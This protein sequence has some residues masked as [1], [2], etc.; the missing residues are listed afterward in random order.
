MPTMKLDAVSITS[1]N[2]TKSAE[3]YRL[4]GFRFPAFDADAK[5]LEPMAEPG[6][7]RLMIDDRGLMQSIT[8]KPPI[9]PN[10][11]SFA[12]KCANPAE[13]DGAAKAIAA[14]GFTVIKEPWDAFWGQRYAIVA[15]PDG[16]HVDLFAPLKA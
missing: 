1:G 2:M 8:G 13:V 11:S 12:M 9:P 6:E 14:A 5:H 7:V 10:H 4:L 16:Y 15:D 3:F